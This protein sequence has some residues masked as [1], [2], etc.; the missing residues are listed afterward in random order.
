MPYHTIHLRVLNIL[1]GISL[2]AFMVKEFN[3]IFG[4]RQPCQDVKFPDVLGTNSIPVGTRLE[5]C[6]EYDTVS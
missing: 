3:E 5:N 2:E 1:H 4:G 6:M